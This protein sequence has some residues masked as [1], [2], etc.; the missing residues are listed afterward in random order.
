VEETVKKLF[1]MMVLLACLAIP[2][3]AFAQGQGDPEARIAQA[4][5]RAAAA[6]VPVEVI[7]AKVTEGRAKGV[8]MERIAQ[9]AER[10]AEAAIR[11][12]EAMTRRGA[13]VDAADLS[14]GADAIEGGVS[15][16]VLATL[17]ETAQGGRRA[18]AIAVLTELVAQGM[19]S[20]E[21]LERVQAA[22]A[23]GAEALANLPAQAAEAR[24]RR[25]APASRPG[26]DGRPAQPGPPAER[27]G[28]RP[29][30][31]GPPAGVPGPGAGGERPGPP[32]GT[33]G[34]RP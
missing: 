1:P 6:G 12:Q 15:A 10:R 8:A 17:A 24:E 30:Q 20:E 32:P 23:R 34:G 33:P 22:M 21:A 28:G 7:Q 5:Q 19:A 4:M 29:A 2:S 3:L 27:P 13:R 18:V 16:V 26:A 9:A 31:P 14:V 11:A 25:G